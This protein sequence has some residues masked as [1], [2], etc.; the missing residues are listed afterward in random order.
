MGK[1]RGKHS[2]HVWH[3]GQEHVFEIEADEFVIGRGEDATV[4][5]DTPEI[6]RQHARVTFRGE[7]ILV[8]DLGSSNGTFGTSTLSP[9]RNASRLCTACGSAPISTLRPAIY[10]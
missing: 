3:K 4:R 2:V 10:P 1:E 9:L 8:R 5:L 6:S 7:S